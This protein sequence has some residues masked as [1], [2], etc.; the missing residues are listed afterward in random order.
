[1]STSIAEQVID[2]YEG[3][4]R[5]IFSDAFRPKISDRLKYNAVARQVE[6]AA[7][8]ASQSLTRFFRHQNVTEQQTADLLHGFAALADL[9]KLDDI[10]NPN[11]T[12]ESKVDELLKHLPVPEPVLQNRHDTIYRVALHSVVQVLMLV[13]PVMAEW[14]KLGFSSTFELPRRIVGRLNQISEQLDTLGRAGETAA[15][16]RYELTYRDYLLQRFHRVDAGTVR[17][18]TNLDVDLRE[19]FV[20][21]SLRSRPKAHEPLDEV[22][23]SRTYE[24]ESGASVLWRICSAGSI[25]RSK[26]TH[27]SSRPGQTFSAPGYRRSPGQRQINLP[28]MAAIEARFR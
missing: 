9:L 1:M 24:F 13:G 14:Q 15:D 25:A 26:G 16:E 7:D 6:E 28:G 10:A 22:G 19:L 4:F 2:F 18:T 5:R 8:A 23:R 17:M 21:P 12:P 20:M 3:L 27:S 11:V